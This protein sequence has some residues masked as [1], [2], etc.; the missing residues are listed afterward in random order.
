MEELKKKVEESKFTDRIHRVLLYISVALGLFL[1]NVFFSFIF[2]KEI[3]KAWFYWLSNL[4]AI[5]T[6]FSISILMADL[7][8]GI[9]TFLED[10]YYNFKARNMMVS[11][12][13]WVKNSKYGSSY[14]ILDYLNDNSNLSELIQDRDGGYREEQRGKVKIQEYTNDL[15]NKKIFLLYNDVILELSKKPLFE[16][17]NMLS[18]IELSPKKNWFFSLVKTIVLFFVS[19][20]TFG[21][22]T[23][24]LINNFSTKNNLE[25]SSIIG[26]LKSFL[27]DNSISTTVAFF[28]IFTPL[29]IL[30]FLL[31][32]KDTRFDEPHVKEYLKKTIARAIE[33][34][35]NGE[36]TESF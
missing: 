6:S 31:V 30:T 34:K 18:F 7:L 10:K 35:E 33:I 14:R 25:V 22:V 9:A 23:E 1:F 11:Y 19:V 17:K 5:V 3:E 32:Y 12:R 24:V 21:N 20:K 4:L 29:F 28:L 8:L 13:S 16:L 2:Y 26:N 27:M 36:E 15:R